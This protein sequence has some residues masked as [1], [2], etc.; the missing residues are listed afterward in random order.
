MENGVFFPIEYEPT[1]TE[2]GSS[3]EGKSSN[4]TAP[5]PDK[6]G[7][8]WRMLLK[9]NLPVEEKIPSR[10]LNAQDVAEALSI[11]LST[12]YLLLERGELPSIRIGR[13]VRIRSEDLEKFVESKVQRQTAIE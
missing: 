6:F 8:T 10:L 11:G 1:S 2:A 13:S 9:D 5:Y 3:E 4:G 7:G 12:V